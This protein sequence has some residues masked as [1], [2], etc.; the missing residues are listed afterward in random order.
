WNYLSADTQTVYVEKST[1]NCFK[2]EMIYDYCTR[3]KHVCKS[4][5]MVRNPWAVVEGIIRR[6]GLPKRE[7]HYQSACI[8]WRNCTLAQLVNHKKFES[9]FI[10]YEQ[11]CS[12]FPLLKE[13]ISNLYPQMNDIDHHN[14]KTDLP[15]HSGKLHSKNKEQQERLGESV[16][17]MVDD[18]CGNLWEEVLLYAN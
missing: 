6:T 5:I 4:I 3:N 7:K 13:K 18:I 2:Y 17:D 11:M 8:H 16:S 15:D 9:E 12:S 1:T 10:T 14:I